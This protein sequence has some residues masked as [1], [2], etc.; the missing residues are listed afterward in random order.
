MEGKQMDILVADVVVG[1][2][3][4]KK[5][6]AVNAIWGEANA[7]GVYPASIHDLYKARGEGK[8]GAFTVPAINLRS[9]TYYLA[10][11]I[12][13]QALSRN[14]GAFIFEIARSEMGYTDQKPL[15]YSTVILAAALREGYKGPVFIQGD[16]FQVNAKSYKDDPKGE[17]EGLKELIKESMDAGFYNIDIDSS[18]VVDLTKTDLLEQQKLNSEI[19]AELTAYIRELQPKGIN[20]SVGG[21]IGEVGS[22]NS[23]PQDLRA[24]MKLYL[25]ALPK[26]VE[27]ISKISVQTGT[28]HGGTVLAD[29]SIAKVIL[30]FNTL[31]CISEAARSEFKMA[32]AVQH[33]ASTLPEDEFHKFPGVETAEVHLA[34]QFQNM[35]LDSRFFP[36]DLK[37]RIYDWLKVEAKNEFKPGMTDEQFFYKSRKK[38]LGPFK[39]DIMSIK[40]SEKIAAEVEKKFGFLF[41]QLNIKD[42]AKL[43]KQFIKEQNIKRQFELVHDKK[44]EAFE[45]DD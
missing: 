17:V 43:T 39:K 34:T 16:H 11:A 1:S 42:T 36:Q 4:Q 10:A 26:G 44:A 12:F 8:F 19:C 37:K 18:T 40:D 30:D 5:E 15:E 22:K 14:A 21:E 24:F 33:G 6:K 28:S 29:G 7:R 41:D 20:V 9:L 3:I 32:G 38:A 31:K 23:T 27:G 13:R 45:G 25:A 35:V 2:D